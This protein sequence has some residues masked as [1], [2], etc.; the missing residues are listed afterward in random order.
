MFAK[1]AFPISNFKTFSYKI[2]SRLINLIQVGTRVEVPFGKKKTRGIITELNNITT[3]KGN[4]KEVL[5]VVDDVTIMTPE[6][7]KLINWM[8]SYYLTPIGQVA[9]TFFP[10]SLST[11]YKPAVSWYVKKNNILD[12]NIIKILQKRAPKQYVVLNH[13]VENKLVKVTKLKKFCSSPLKICQSLQKIKLVTLIEKVLLPDSTGFIF[14]PVHKEVVFNEEQK[15]AVNDINNGINKENFQSFLLHGVTGSGK[16]EIYI[17]AVRNCLLKDK[18]AIILLPEISL[19]PQI[20]GR[21]RAVFGDKI[22]LWHSKLTPSQRSWTWK[23][24]CKGDYKVVIGAR[25]AIFAPIKNLGLIVIDEEQETSFRQDSPDPRYHARDVALVR[26]KYENAVVVLASATPSLETYYNYKIKKIKYLYLSKRFGGAKYPKVFL[27]DMLSEQKESGKFGQILSGVLQDKIEDRLQKKEQVILLHN[28]RGYSPVVK[29][30]DCG[31]VA[32]CNNCKV[33]LTYHQKNDRLICHYCSYTVKSKWK[34]CLECKSVNLL[35]RG[36]GTQRVEHL[37]ENTFMDAKI[38]RIDMD[39]S[40]TSKGVTSM[41]KSFSNGEIDILIGTQMIA[42]GLDFPNTTLVGIINSDLGLYLP[43]FRSG[44]RIFQLIYQASG[45]AGR[46]DKGGEV[47]I[48]TFAP[49]N[50]VIKMVSELNVLKYYDITLKEREELDYPPYS[51]LAKIEITG[52]QNYSV[53]NTIIKL[54]DSFKNKYKGLEVLGPA[55]C[56][57]EKVKNRFRYQIILKSSKKVDPNGKLLHVFI[58]EN[59]KIFK[60]S[61]R[62]RNNRINV[63]FDPLSLI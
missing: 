8:S 7:W 37:I 52:L 13:L 31:E 60:G 56:F 48:Q 51:W 40:Q 30:R 5:D 45:R 14:D 9:R 34:S 20:A 39:T 41:L 46:K 16:T 53:N 19:T 44:E 42:K 27:V 35:Y 6:I 25:S 28:R 61:Y 50:P 10:K 11:K 17:E 62:L 22:A 63:H 43:D 2:P 58:R 49:E 57:L 4:V 1:V 54:A 36:T 15:H 33:A 55:P 29:C 12:E 26:G 47:V 38:A 3:F 23:Q 59:I 18:T 24:I 21:F 32:N